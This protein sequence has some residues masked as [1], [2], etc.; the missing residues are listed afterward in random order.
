[1]GTRAHARAVAKTICCRERRG[2]R[3]AGPQDP[4]ASVGSEG[5]ITC[6]QCGYVSP[7]TAEFCTN[8][9]RPLVPTATPPLAEA[10]LL[11]G[12]SRTRTGFLLLF[13]AFLLLVVPLVSIVGT[14]L[15]IVAV[16]LIYMGAEAYGARHKRN[17]LASI[18]IWIVIFVGLVATLVAL[19]TPALVAILQGE[20]LD[21]FQD[22]L[23][24]LSIASAVGGAL[25]GVPYLLVGQQLLDTDR[26][27][28]WVVLAVHVAVAAGQGVWEG[29]VLES[30]VE[31]VSTGNVPFLGVGLDPVGFLFSLVN[32]LWAFLYFRIYQRVVAGYATLSA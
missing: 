15:A 10:E 7:A 27:L 28:G 1:M 29:L 3:L 2:K 4:G 16:I 19:I 17:V 24:T 9:G 14:L 21:P 32:L 25:F 11:R 5:S 20:S 22:L 30:S 31:A 12:R 8:C 23:L 6:P 26:S 18:L 13:I